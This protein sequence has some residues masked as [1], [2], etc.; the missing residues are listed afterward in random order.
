MSKKI[1]SH[2]PNTITCL[3]L[4]S[5]CLGIVMAFKCYEPVGALQGWQWT[6]VFIFA[7]ALFDFCDGAA[8]RALKAYSKIGAELDS[9]ADLVSFGVAP[10]LMIFNIMNHYAPDSI[11]NYLALAPVVFGALRLARFNVY[12]SGSTTF[13]GLP[14]PSAALFLMGLAGWVSQHGYPGSVPMIIAVLLASF[15]MVGN[16]SMFSLKFKNFSLNENF[17][18]YVLIFASITFV[19][20]YGITG[21]GWAILFYV[22]L[23]L[24]SR[25][26]DI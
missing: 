21:F 19:V 8:A 25:N 15:A 24:V 4:L 3:N 16:F 18:R 6:C 7:A 22:V 2:I 13:R 17:R 1:I 10:S 23:S 5:G 12:D 9:L 11:F 20:G 14:I 26:N